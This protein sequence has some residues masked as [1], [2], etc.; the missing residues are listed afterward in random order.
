MKELSIEK[1]EMISGGRCSMEDMMSYAFLASY[2]AGK[3]S[4]LSAFYS[5]RLMACMAEI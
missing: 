5:A 3:D 4:V 2:Y 1:M